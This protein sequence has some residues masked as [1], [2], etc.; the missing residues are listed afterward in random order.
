MLD[1]IEMLEAIGSDASL[2]YASTVELTNLLDQGQ[3]TTALTAAV[4]SGDASH[5]AREFGDMTNFVPQATQ[6]FVSSDLN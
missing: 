4:M 5:L 3:A 2:R 1:T 6:S